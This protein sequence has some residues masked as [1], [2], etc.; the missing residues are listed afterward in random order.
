[1]CSLNRLASFVDRIADFMLVLL[2]KSLAV[3]VYFMVEL[4]DG[5]K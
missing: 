2:S 5:Q 3:L 1:M 4:V